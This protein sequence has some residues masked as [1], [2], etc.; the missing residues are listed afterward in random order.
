MVESEI[1]PLRVFGASDGLRI[2]LRLFELDFDYLCSG[3]VQGFK[4]LLHTPEEIPQIS[5][6]YYRIPL[7]HEVILSVKPNVM[8]TSESLQEYNPVR[9][10]CYF[11][12]ERYLKYFRIYTQRNCELECI[13]NATVKR[14]GCVSFAMPSN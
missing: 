8:T 9:R 3:P 6:Y 7:D 1:Y 5:K 13:T 4:L 10:Q 2:N 12:W 11:E 14:C